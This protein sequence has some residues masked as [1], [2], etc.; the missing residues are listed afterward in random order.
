M[1]GNHTHNHSEQNCCNGEKMT[2]EQFSLS[3]MDSGSKSLAN[4]LR[5]SFS[6]LKI[7]M[8]IL[9]VLFIGS[10]VFTVGPGERAMVLRFGK[11]RGQGISERVLGP[12]LHWA[13]PYPVD[14]VI[15][16]PGEG[17]VGHVAIEHFWYD[18]SGGRVLPSLDP[19]MDGYCLTRNDTVFDLE[20]SGSDYNIVHLKAVLTYRIKD[21]EDFLKNINIKT[22]PPGRNYIDVID[23]SVGPVLNSIASEAIVTTLVKFSID[24]AIKN[25]EDITRQCENTLQRKLDSIESGIDI[26]TIQITQITWPRQVDDDFVKS[27]KARNQADTL[28]RQ[29]KGDAES[30]LNEAGG[31]IMFE[32]LTSEDLTDAQRERVWAGASGTARQRISEA[33]TYRTRVVE[34]ARANADYLLKLLPEYRKRPELVL[35]RI[36][37]DAIQEVLTNVQETI[38]AEPSASATNREFR[39]L[40]N[41]DPMLEKKKQGEN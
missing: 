10:G 35:Q 30:M 12:G 39:I 16:F 19:L 20:G 25:D 22:P 26:D 9:V 11:I 3:G 24:E 41:R 33:R 17:T 18:E 1:S 15:K 2:D 27:T 4:A 7:I 14:E 6:V 5:I 23:E 37:Q 32:A 38:I 13:I 28:V 21:C 40:V 8:V 36:Y 34:S 29:A 31:L